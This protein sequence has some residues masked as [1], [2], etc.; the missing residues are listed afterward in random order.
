MQFLAGESTGMGGRVYLVSNPK[1]QLN[2]HDLKFT[3]FTLLTTNPRI[4]NVGKS[5]GK[6]KQIMRR[7]STLFM[8]PW[9]RVDVRNLTFLDHFR[10]RTT[11]SLV[12][13]VW[14]WG[15]E[16]RVIVQTNLKRKVKKKLA[17]KV[18]N[19][20]WEKQTD[21]KAWNERH[22]E[23]YLISLSDSPSPVL[24]S[25]SISKLETYTWVAS[26]KWA[27]PRYNTIWEKKKKD[28]L[29]WLKESIQVCCLCRRR[30]GFRLQPLRDEIALRAETTTSTLFWVQL[31]P[32]SQDLSVSVWDAAGGPGVLG[33]ASDKIHRNIVDFGWM[34]KSTR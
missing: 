27:L 33:K 12:G 18:E 10:H 2:T 6:S 3:L 21:K 8:S 29:A 13:K 24:N 20:L 23:V 15:S 28:S 19:K 25:H 17:S 16:R 14:G 22:S 7:S 1:V 9:R 5:I 11:A 34:E 26:P 31:Q 32:R 30:M 4:R